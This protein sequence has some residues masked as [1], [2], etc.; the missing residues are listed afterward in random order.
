M[1]QEIYAPDEEDEDEDGECFDIKEEFCPAATAKHGLLVAHVCRGEESTW[2]RALHPPMFDE[3]GYCMFNGCNAG[4]FKTE[5]EKKSHAASH[6]TARQILEELGLNAPTLY[7]KMALKPHINFGSML[8][9][10]SS[11]GSLA[12]PEKISKFNGWV[13]GGLNE[14]IDYVFEVVDSPTERLSGK[15]LEDWLARN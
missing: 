6:P 14:E 11:I 5:E 7:K 13:W 2:H 10:A 15:D 8:F 9:I 1:T 12:D 4:P 3:D